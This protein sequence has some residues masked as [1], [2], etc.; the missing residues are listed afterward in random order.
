MHFR[1][2]DPMN[3]DERRDLVPHIPTMPC[4]LAFP[5]ILWT[6]WWWPI[7]R[8]ETCSCSY[9]MMCF[10]W[11][12]IYMRE[13]ERERYTILCIIS[14]RILQNDVVTVC[15][16]LYWSV[17]FARKFHDVSINKSNCKFYPVDFS[18]LYNCSCLSR[19]SH[20]TVV[21]YFWQSFL[22]QAIKFSFEQ[23]LSSR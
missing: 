5:H 21:N 6:T 2:I 19:I 7:C 1:S 23:K 13:R 9:L 16:S 18:V 8:A 10:D 20:S 4:V 11:I 3:H 22:L 12:Y 15:F 14:S 17:H